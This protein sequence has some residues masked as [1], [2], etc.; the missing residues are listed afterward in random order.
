MRS[1]PE[2]EDFGR[3]VVKDDCSKNGQDSKKC[4]SQLFVLTLE[5]QNARGET[6]ARSQILT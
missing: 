5:T 2:R 3:D 6:R 1:V 4:D